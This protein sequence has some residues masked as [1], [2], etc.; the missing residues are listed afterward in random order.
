MPYLP[1]KKWSKRIAIPVGIIYFLHLT[2]PTQHHF[3]RYLLE[4]KKYEPEF[5]MR[6]EHPACRIRFFEGF[7]Y[8]YAEIDTCGFRQRHTSGAGIDTGMSRFTYYGMLN[9]FFVEKQLY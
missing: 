8:A 7:I 1:I 9:N 2:A 5:A 6:L 4:R 3:E